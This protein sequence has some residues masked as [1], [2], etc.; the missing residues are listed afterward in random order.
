MKISSFHQFPDECLNE[1]LNRFHGLLWKTPTHGFSKL[2]QLNI[3]IDGLQPHSKQLLDASIG[4]KIKLMTPEEA[5]KLIE[6]MAANDHVILRDPE[7]NPQEETTR[8]EELLVQFM[9]E[10]RSHQNSTDAPLRNLEVELAKLVAERP[11]ETFAVNTEMK[12]KEEC[13]VIFTERER[14]E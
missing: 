14:K 10:T 7:P 11:T 1:T 5:M 8:L 9:Q 6:N 13:K 2:F 4:G 3:F 12:P